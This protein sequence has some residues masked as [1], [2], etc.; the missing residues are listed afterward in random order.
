MD[1]VQG[2]IQATA[3]VNQEISFDNTPLFIAAH[4]G[5][6]E[7]VRDSIDANVSVNDQLTFGP[8]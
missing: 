3:N 2:L 7:A 5:Q 8:H 4:N 6:T 1:I